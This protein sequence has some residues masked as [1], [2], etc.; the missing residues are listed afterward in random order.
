[1]IIGIWV[2]KQIVQNILKKMLKC[3]PKDVYVDRTVLKKY[4]ISDIPDAVF[5]P[6]YEKSGILI[7]IYL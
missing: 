4:K 5:A 1:M 6:G 2:E 7:M 3:K